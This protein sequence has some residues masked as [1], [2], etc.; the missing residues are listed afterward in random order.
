MA[1]DKNK[2]KNP[3]EDAERAL[4][5]IV[6]DK[7]EVVS[8]RDKKYTIKSLKKGTRLLVSNILVKSSVVDESNKEV[9]E[10][11][12]LEDKVMAKCMAAFIL[13]SYWTLSFFFGIVWKIYWRWLYYVK[14]YT[15]SDYYEA[16]Q[17]CKKK[18]D[19]E[20]NAYMMNI[21][22]LTATRTTTMTMTRAEVKRIQVEKSLEQL[23]QPQKNSLN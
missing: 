19:K 10:D 20:T 7:P 14:Q 9:K 15:D 17:I 8:I 18:A 3:S 16:L 1:E 21:M 22:L 12:K 5:D 6:M 13:N 11:P 2:I 23:G 4:L